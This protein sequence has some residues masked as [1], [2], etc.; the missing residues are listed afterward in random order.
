MLIKILLFWQNKKKKTNKTIT[1]P[2]IM[3]HEYGSKYN[4][5]V[6]SYTLLVRKQGNNFQFIVVKVI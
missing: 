4:L 6:T 5:Q 2:T 3:Q 1:L